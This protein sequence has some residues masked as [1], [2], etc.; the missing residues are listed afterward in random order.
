M[1]ILIFYGSRHRCPAQFC[2]ESEELPATISP[3]DYLSASR[4]AFRLFRRVHPRVFV[5]V[6]RVYDP[7]YCAYFAPGDLYEGA[8]LDDPADIHYTDDGNAEW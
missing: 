8:H 6:I 7:K 3:K 1:F 4:F 2:V 5:H